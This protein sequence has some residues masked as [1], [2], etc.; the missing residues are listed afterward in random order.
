LDNSQEP[1]NH[2]TLHDWFA[3][4]LTSETLILINKQTMLLVAELKLVPNSH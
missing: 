4:D 1:P 3:R 2:F